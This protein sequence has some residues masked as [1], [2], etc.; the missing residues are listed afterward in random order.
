[1]MEAF[2]YDLLRKSIKKTGEKKS[3]GDA[4]VTSGANAEA[5]VVQINLTL[6]VLYMDLVD[7][8]V[9]PEF[10]AKVVDYLKREFT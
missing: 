1:M 3:K 10:A 2:P 6:I 8:E 4:D 9:A 5:V 7:G